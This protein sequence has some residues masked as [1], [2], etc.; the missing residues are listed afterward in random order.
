MLKIFGIPN[1]DTVK[2][3]RVWFAEQGVEFS[4]HNF[5]K[6]G[7]EADIVSSWLEKLGADVV[8]NKKSATWR[9]LSDDEKQLSGDELIA[10]LLNHPTLIKRPVIED[11]DKLTVGFTGDVKGEWQ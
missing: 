11:G 8:V 2:K 4:F 9:K 7:L 6:D 5:R 1:C 3:A 10:L